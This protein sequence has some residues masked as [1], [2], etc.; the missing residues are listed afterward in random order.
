MVEGCEG[1]AV[2][3]TIIIVWGPILLHKESLALTVIRSL[4]VVPLV[5]VTLL[6]I[7][8]DVIDQPEGKDQ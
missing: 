7:M 6:V 5:T 3:V 2:V 4:L 1:D 8:P